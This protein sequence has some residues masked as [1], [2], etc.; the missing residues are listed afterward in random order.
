MGTQS[1]RPPTINSWNWVSLSVRAI[2]VAGPEKCVWLFRGYFHPFRWC[3]LFFLCDTRQLEKAFPCALT[4]CVCLVLYF[5]GYI[6]RL[7]WLLNFSGTFWEIAFLGRSTFS[8]HLFFF[9]LLTDSVSSTT[10]NNSRSLGLWGIGLSPEFLVGS[11]CA[12][13][14][15]FVLK[16]AQIDI[17]TSTFMTY[18]SQQFVGGMIKNS[19]WFL[20][21]LRRFH[22]KPQTE[23]ELKQ[24]KSQKEAVTETKTTYI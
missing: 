24:G 23:S 12:L 15:A 9:F 5:W 3:F 6:L 22:W 10:V 1:S 20:W 14:Y 13:K 19:E 8:I 11:V 21:I 7:R 16:L 17:F 4:V 18:T 2:S